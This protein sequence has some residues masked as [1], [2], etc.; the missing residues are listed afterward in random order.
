MS[1]FIIRILQNKT[2][3]IQVQ[4]CWNIVHLLFT[5]LVSFS[6]KTLNNWVETGCRFTEIVS[7]Q[8]RYH[9]SSRLARWKQRT[10]HTKMK[11]EVNS[12]NI[13]PL[14]IKPACLRIMGMAIL[15]T[16]DAPV[17]NLAAS[18]QLHEER[19]RCLEELQWIQE[20]QQT[21]DEIPPKWTNDVEQFCPVSCLKG[22]SFQNHKYVELLTLHHLDWWGTEWIRHQKKDKA[23]APEHT[24]ELRRKFSPRSGI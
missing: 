4:T 14:P 8:K 9:S 3:F 24:S 19:N 12:M 13:A 18:I 23:L 1:V 7:S 11:K 17:K 20:Y 16:A 21:I 15:P 5:F 22:N 2:S 6:S 10:V